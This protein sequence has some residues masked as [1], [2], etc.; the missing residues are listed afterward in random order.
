[1]T[2]LTDPPAESVDCDVVVVGS[3]G[4]ALVGALAAADHG[5]ATVVV[6]KTARFGGTSA[7]SGASCW[8]P[9]TPIQQ[10]AVGDSIEEAGRYL[11]HVL[12][13][14]APRDQA[15]MEA[16]LQTSPRVV[17]F[18]TSHDE[19]PFGYQFFP[20]YF[21]APG[22]QPMGRSIVPENLPL[23]ELGELA[24]VVRARVDLDRADADH[25]DPVT[26][27][28]A[29]IGRLLLALEATG[30]VTAFTSTP[31][32]EL[33]RDGD[34]IVGIRVDGPSGPVEVRARRG[35]LLAAGGFERS[36]S[37]RTDHDTPGRAD[38]SMAPDGANTGDAIRAAAAVGAAT[39]L[40][41]EA[42]WCPVL[43]QP[44]GSTSFFLGMHGG[45]I[46]DQ[47]GRRYA[48]ES[49]P[50]D[51]MGRR[52]A[53]DPD[54]RVPSHV[55]FDSRF[56][57]PPGIAVPGVD[58]DACREAGLW[59]DADTVADLAERIGVD[60]EALAG[61]VATF[62][63]AADAGVDTEHHRGE[64]AFGQFFGQRGEGPNPALVPIDQ[65]PF[66]AARVLLG[67]LGTKGGLRT[68]PDGQVLDERD[69]PLAGLYATSNTVASFTGG[70]YPAPGIPLGT[71]MVA[72]YRAAEAMAAGQ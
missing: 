46:V 11:A 58:P 15:R 43:E 1:M 65:P 7:Y 13:E 5:L 30:R 32:R 52:M 50:Y 47:Q 49:L 44:D 22:R 61:T 68:D 33:V 51:Q 40:M 25:A 69:Q 16:F 3:G 17:E 24:D 14:L 4:G 31:M 9:G 36:A 35:V 63:E 28:G 39:D 12:G 55:V 72:A 19:L 60:P 21:D 56:R 27:G 71:S 53:A 26:G 54:T 34:R 67:D 29:L 64:D 66:T 2:I 37:M 48:N 23:S 45:I 6:E 57:T 20:D 42:W 10:E 70:V 18:L 8:L 38:W 62:N 59:H 41:D